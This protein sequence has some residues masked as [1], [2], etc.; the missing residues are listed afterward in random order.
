MRTLHVIK[1][2]KQMYTRSKNVLTIKKAL[3]AKAIAKH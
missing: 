2:T 1:A 3:E